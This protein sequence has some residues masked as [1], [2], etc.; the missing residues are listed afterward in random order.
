MFEIAQEASNDG[1]GLLPGNKDW[2]VTLNYK[3][4]PWRSISV[5]HHDSIDCWKKYWDMVGLSEDKF[6]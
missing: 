6:K 2:K 4:F 3:D 1:V 5:K